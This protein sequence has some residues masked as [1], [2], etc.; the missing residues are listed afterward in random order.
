MER[1]AL[2]RRALAPVMA[3]LGVIG[4]LAAIGGYLLEIT[5]FPGFVTYWFSVGGL[6]VAAAFLLIRKQA[7]AAGEPF[8]S[9]PTKRVTQAILPPLVCGL[10]LTAIAPG[11]WQATA[12]WAGL[13][14][15]ALHAGGFFTP[16]GI[17]RL[18]WLFIAAGIGIIVLLQRGSLPGVHA[19]GAMGAMFGALHLAYAAYLRV[20]EQRS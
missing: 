18:G 7:L 14:G 2:Y 11:V 4:T 1:A 19:H 10:A 5:S 13:Y 17:R 9:P 3:L 12:L 6:S 8:W 16:G 20:R 15:A